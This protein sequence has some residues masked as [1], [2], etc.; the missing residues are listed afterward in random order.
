MRFDIRYRC[1]FSYGELVRESQNEAR[2]CPASDEGQQLVNYR[3]TARPSCRILSF[4]DYWGTRVDAFGVREPHL[5]LD[6]TAE[7]S[8]ETRHRR[9]P[10]VAPR[11][12][13]LR[14]PAFVDDHIEYLGRSPHVSW[15]QGAAAVAAHAVELAGDDVVGQVLAMHRQVGSRLRYIPGSTGIGVEVEQVLASGQGVCQDYAHLAVALCRSIGIP[16]RYVSGYLFA[17]DE[18][19]AEDPG[20]EMV[21]VQTHAWFEAAIPGFGW[22]A[23]DPT[24]EQ[25]VGLRHVKIGH[26]RDYDDVPPLRGVYAGPTGSEVDVS[27][28]IRRVDTPV[29]P[30]LEP[31]QARTRPS[32]P[33][34][35]G[36]PAGDLTFPPQY[37]DQRQQQQ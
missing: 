5:Y 27:V 18:T 13:A 1:G 21:T 16:A 28:E 14:S 24:N 11:P 3:M 31:R 37:Q 12:E 35:D 15:G 7:A 29:V 23:L 19:A 33:M 26:G 22:L 8:V 32:A 4:T 20:D 9:L 2:V 36:L 6:V 10:T 17:Q 30:A 34:M 25:Q